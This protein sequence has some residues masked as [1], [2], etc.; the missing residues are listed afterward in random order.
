[1]EQRDYHYY[2]AHAA[3]V[4]LEEITSSAK[5][6]NILQ[7]LRDGDRA[8]DSIVLCSLRTTFNWLFV[9]EQIHLCG[10]LGLEFVIREDDNLG[11]LGYFIGKSD[12]LK[13]FRIDY[14]PEGEQQIHTSQMHSKHWRQQ[15]QQ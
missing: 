14:L 11:W 7:R 13:Q 1:M 8:L 4:N 12:C 5:N 2:E 15:S 10:S 3:D 6:A 9:V